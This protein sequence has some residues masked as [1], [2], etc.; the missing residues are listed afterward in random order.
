M[1]ADSPSNNQAIENFSSDGS[2]TV[3]A[4]ERLGRGIV[5]DPITTPVVN[6]SAH[7]FKKTADLIEFKVLAGCISGS[8]KLISAVRN[9]HY[10]LGDALNPK[11][12]KSNHLRLEDTASS[13]AAAKFNCI[14]DEI[15][16]AHPK[17]RRFYYP[18]LPGYQIAK[19]DLSPSERAKYGIM[20]NLVRFSFGVE[21]FED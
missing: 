5:T 20:D 3:H 15:L 21:D 11:C 13:R 10:I 12:C 16:E 9:L 4:G 18:G 14:K 1:V 8:D 19:R 7:F 6:T 17:V 2:I